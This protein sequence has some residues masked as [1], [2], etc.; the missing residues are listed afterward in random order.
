MAASRRLSFSMPTN[1]RPKNK[2][3]DESISELKDVYQTIRYDW[4]QILDEHANPIDTAISL[5]DDSSVGLAHRLEDFRLL[6]S[7]T[8]LALRHVVNEHHELFN[9][10]IGTYHMLLSTLTESQEDSAS[11]K[12]FLESSNKE[13]HDRSDLLKDLNQTSIRYAGMIDIL[14]AIAELNSIPEKIEQ[15]VIDKKIHEVYDVISDG[16]KL[17]EKYN[18]WSLPA[19]NGIQSY[20]ELQSNKLFDMI[21]DELQNEIYLKNTRGNADNSPK[22]TIFAWTNMLHSKTPQ[23]SSFSSLI[24]SKN[25]EQYVNNSANLDMT[26]IVD[27]MTQPIENFLMNQLPEL[28]THM[29]SNES[30]IDYKVLLE[31][32]SNP[33]TESFHYIYMLLIT[34]SKLSRLHQVTEILLDTNQSELHGLINRTTEEIKSQNARALSKLSKVPATGHIQD[35]TLFEIT[36]HNGFNDAAVV[37]LQDLFG[38]IFIKCLAVFHRHKA[39]SEIVKLIEAGQNLATTR[40]VKTTPGYKAVDV[41]YNHLVNIWNIIKKEL[42]SSMLSYIYDEA[43]F[44]SEGLNEATRIKDQS[45][46]YNA[47]KKTTKLFKFENVSYNAKKPQDDLAGILTDIF[48]GFNV[49]DENGKSAIIDSSSPYIQSESFNA[50]IE[51]LVPKNLFNMRIILEFFLIFIEGSQRVFLDFNTEHEK[52]DGNIPPHIKAAFQFFDDFMKISFLS[53]LRESIEMAFGEQVGGS[54][55]S[56]SDTDR[57]IHASGLKLDLISLNQDFST[58]VTV[59]A[60][61]QTQNP[62]D[63]STNLVIYEN[64]FNFKKL[65]MELC[66]MLN[67]SLTYRED[68]CDLTL[69]VLE[70]FAK[71]YNNLYEELLSTGDSTIS[72]GNQSARPVS[73]I[74][75]WMKISALSEVSGRILQSNASGNTAGL[76]DLIE[77]ES[78][79]I[80]FDNNNQVYSITKDDLLDSEAYSQVVHLLLTTSWILSWLPL[81]KKESNY[82]VVYESDGDDATTHAV[83]KL[84]YNWSFLENGRPTINFSANSSDIL[85]H[86]V[87]LALNSAKCTQF[88][89]IIQTFGTIRDRALL[90]LRYDLRCKA[91]YYVSNSFKLVDWMPISE[92]GDADHY[93]GLFNQEVFAVDNKLSKTLSDVERESIF[94][95]LT[96]FLNDLIIQGSSKI[97]KI[98]S[99]GIKRILLNIYTL[100]QMLRSLAKSPASIDFTKASIYFEMF[101]LN[102]FT[103]TNRVKS[104]DHNYTKSAFNNMARMI[105]SEK[106]ADGTGSSFN[107]GKYADLL[108]KIDEIMQ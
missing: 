35:Q 19:M 83:D 108:K 25:L 18:L 4:P 95:G 11:I 84:R 12:D 56:R 31:S 41:S 36:G 66:L 58:D 78:Q 26:E 91:I 13:I 44:K 93:I 101:T 50:M 103:F 82:S 15:L 3:M 42:K 14:D 74:S 72:S 24:N 23:L 92:P 60:N 97:K 9:N 79:V 81:I 90:A 57:S 52:K 86:N 46:I 8:E 96:R 40:A 70:N 43:A 17:A 98:N 51:V 37:V 77:S 20:L 5:L 7:K 28:H 33:S 53:H 106:L 71:E 16:Y 100:Q 61:V 94:V 38:S 75:K 39:V 29:V 76:M 107:K 22:Q 21:I 6:K 80:L 34:A 102:E 85:Q 99:N 2:S 105:Y 45:K 1:G 104:N 59:I 89:Q 49:S 32:K 48:P 30:I 27:F 67:T 73:Q 68:Y 63:S 10:S 69:R 54:Y 64:A 62:T 87:Y 88:D 65:F 55:T 47:M